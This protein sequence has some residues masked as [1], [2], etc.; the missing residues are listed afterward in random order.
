MKKQPYVYF[1]Y[2]PFL[3]EIAS[4]TAENASWLYLIDKAN[5]SAQ[6]L[7]QIEQFIDIACMY[8]YTATLNAEFEKILYNTVEEG[9]SLSAE[10]IIKI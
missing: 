6:K 3:G 9:G 8:F 10:S 2:P 5:T 4:T 7:Y 1:N